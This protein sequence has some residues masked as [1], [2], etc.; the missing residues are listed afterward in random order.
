MKLEDFG[1][2]DNL[3]KF[4]IGNNLKDFEPQLILLNLR[5]DEGLKS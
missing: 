5:P 1:Y 4:R 3:E 2:N